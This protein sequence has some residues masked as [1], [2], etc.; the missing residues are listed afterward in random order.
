MGRGHG[1]D[2]FEQLVARL[3]TFVNDPLNASIEPRTI[4]S[5]EVFGCEDNDGDRTEIR[6][7]P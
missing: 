2:V 6:S 4:R 7:V 3:R 1:A 5:G